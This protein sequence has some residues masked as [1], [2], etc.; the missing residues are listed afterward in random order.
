MSGNFDEVVRGVGMGLLEEGDDDFVNAVVCSR[1][2]Q[3][4]KDGACGFEL[5]TEFQQG[6][7]YL[8]RFWTR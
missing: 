5:A 8:T 6:S 7:S 4:A 1:L 2:D 3:F